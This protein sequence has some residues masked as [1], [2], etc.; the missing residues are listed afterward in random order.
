MH[1]RG[2]IA[3]LGAK[4]KVVAVIR[5]DFGNPVRRKI[6]T[7]GRTGHIII[8]TAIDASGYRCGVNN[9]GTRPVGRQGRAGQ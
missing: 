1:A 3:G 7:A 9:T 8:I 2:K 4:A 6:R 5:V